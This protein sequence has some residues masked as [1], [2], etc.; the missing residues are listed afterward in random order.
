MQLS[1]SVHYNE[2]L[3]ADDAVVNIVVSVRAEPGGDDRPAGRHAEVILL[4]CSGSMAAPQEKIYNARLAAIGAVDALP[5]GVAFAVVEGTDQATMVYPSET[6]LAVADEQTRAAAKDRIRRLRPH[7]GTA[8]GAWLRLADRLLDTDPGAIGH[9]LLVTDGRNETEPRAVLEAAVAACADR[10][11]VDCWAIGARDGRHAWSGDELLMV[12]AALGANPVVPVEDPDVL[13]AEF[14][15]RL[16]TAMSR[17]IANASLTVRT[18]A[19]ARVRSIKQVHPTITDLSARGIPGS[20]AATDYP[21][22]AWGPGER[23]DFFLTLEVQPMP[24]GSSRRIAW[25]GIGA[26][27]PDPRMSPVQVTWSHEVEQEGSTHGAVEHYTQHQ[28]LERRL[29]EAREAFESGRH[30]EAEQLLGAAV[31]VAF[32]LNDRDLLDLLRRLCEWD[33]PEHGVVTLRPDIRDDLWPPFTVLSARTGAWRP[34]PG[35]A[36]RSSPGQAAAPDG[37]CPRCGFGE[38]TGYYCDVCGYP[39]AESA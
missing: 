3:P 38:R 24:S 15:T 34:D 11:T 33:D 31:R 10:F 28:T 20:D 18:A 8:I 30:A 1:T 26:G 9:A 35:E 36:P 23:R 17:R 16:R 12:A 25:I 2:Y 19:V 14:T 37:P 22:G 21:T 4:D 5:D 39:G 32:H 6:K 13:V 27:E 29:T 7:G